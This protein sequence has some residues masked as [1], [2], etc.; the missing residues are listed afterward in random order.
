MQLTSSVALQQAVSSENERYLKEVGVDPERTSSEDYTS[1]NDTH[2]REK[3]TSHT[4]ESGQ[5][6][7]KTK[8]KTKKVK[9]EKQSRSPSLY[10]Q[11]CELA[12]PLV[13]T[14]HLSDTSNRGLFVYRNH[15]ISQVG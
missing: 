15:K 7:G 14:E 4:A 12:H 8:T 6:T 2:V 1:D 13:P 9:T 10:Q 3:K 5:K 11:F